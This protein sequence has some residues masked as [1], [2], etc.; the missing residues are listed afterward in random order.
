MTR[1]LV[2][3]MKVMFA[4]PCNVRF[5]FVRPHL[6]CCCVLNLSVF[7]ASKTKTASRKGTQDGDTNSNGSTESERDEEEEESEIVSSEGD[8]CC[9]Y[10]SMRCLITVAGWGGGGGVGR[11][12]EGRGGRPD[13]VGCLRV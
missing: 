4:V 13:N 6:F 12:G 7:A 5:T 11:G 2:G 10:N 9:H 8:R 3:N 1:S